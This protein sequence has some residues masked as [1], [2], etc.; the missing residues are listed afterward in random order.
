MMRDMLSDGRIRVIS[1]AAILVMVIIW[2]F[3]VRTPAYS[4][5]ID[6]Q[7]ALVVAD[8]AVVNTVLQEINDAEMAQQID[9]KLTFAK[10][11]DVMPAEKVA[12]ELKYALEPKTSGATLVVNGD[13]LVC[14]QDGGTAQALL[15]QL[16][17]EYSTLAEGEKLTS[18]E[19]AEDVQ[20]IEGTIICADL[21]DRDAALNLI[22]LGTMKP[23]IYVVEEGD[24]M[25]SIARAHDMYVSD[26]VAANGIQEDS[27]LSLEQEII[28]N[29]P[30][31]LITV[32]AQV[33]G[34]QKVVIPYQ[35][36][37]EQDNSL[38]G[39]KIKTEGK[40]G[41]KQVSYTATL[42]NGIMENKEV[43]EEQVIAAAVDKVIVKGRATQVAS[44]GGSTG[45]LIWPV[46]GSISQSYGGRHTGIDIAGSAGSNI[47]AAD[48]G[49][50][51]FAGWQGGYGNFVI[52]KHSNGL[53]TRYAH[54][55]KILVS[56][57]QSV[58][59][60]QTVATRGSTGNSTGP[61]LHFE[62]MQNGSFCNPLNYLR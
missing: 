39:I 44:R 42:R 19:F 15:E 20:I 12:A 35:T 49:V 47:S 18:V 57:G 59:Q 14:L 29:K 17:Q 8:K 24:S 7:K 55:S 23:Q 13:P 61:H 21:V 4:V 41:E 37:T 54:C 22:K 32:V 56:S 48:G 46:A 45:R 27:I 50:V 62:V 36:I 33:E 38:S 52:I 26:I 25:W 5:T 43:V 6:G 11:S 3:G 9:V 30:A 58:S 31:P 60:G 16:K 53:V 40:N 2:C 28:L 10:R 1:L 34:N 51:T